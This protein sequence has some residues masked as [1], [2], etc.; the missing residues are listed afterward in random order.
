MDTTEPMTLDQAAE[1]LIQPEQP[2]EET[3]EDSAFEEETESEEEQPEEDSDDEEEVEIED[4]EDEPESDSEEDEDDGEDDSDEVDDEEADQEPEQQLHTVKVDG[5]EFQVNLEELKRGYSGQK[6]VQKGMQEAAEA[7]KQAKS[8]HNAL[9]QERQTLMAL[10]N[11]VQQGNLTPPQPPNREM[12][13]SD[14]LG[15]ME[16]DMNYKDQLKAYEQNVAQVRN[17]LQ[18]QTQ[19]EQQARAAYVQQEA[20]QLVERVPEMT[21]QS[22]A[23]AYMGKVKKAA[24]AFGYTPEEINGIVSHRDIMVLAAASKALEMEDG[25]KIVKE[26]SKK[27]RKPLKAGARKINRKSDAV[28]KQRDKLA[29]SGSIED[30]MALILDPNLK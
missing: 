18:Q 26:K 17:Q 13:D 2:T 27:A 14:P 9:M 6:Y 4:D 19:A 25:K 22:K 7:Q 10:M 30:A 21:D 24:E 1:A 8:V 29:R 28:R 16:A 20:K 11:Q 5:E 15:Y 3:V 23:E 12:F